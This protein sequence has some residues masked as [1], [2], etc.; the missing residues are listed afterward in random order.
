VLRYAGPAGIHFAH[1]L[2]KAGYNTV[3]VLEAEE[4][5]GGKSHTKAMDSYPTVR[6][7]VRKRKTYYLFDH[8]RLCDS[9]YG[10]RHVY[11]NFQSNPSALKILPSAPFSVDVWHALKFLV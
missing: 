8:P 10:K 4:R 3:V 1:L 9:S 5:V 2:K 11:S 7:E 6:H